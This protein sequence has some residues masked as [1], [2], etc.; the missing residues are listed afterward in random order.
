MFAFPATPVAEGVYVQMIE[1][2]GSP[3][4]RV[5]ADDAMG[6]RRAVE[7]LG[8]PGH[9]RLAYPNAQATHLAHYS[10][11]ATYRPT[12]SSPTDFTSAELPPTITRKRPGSTTRFRS[13]P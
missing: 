1:K 2:V 12:T 11:E 4:V 13:G 9:R 6:T 7:L 8:H 5:L 3:V 10:V